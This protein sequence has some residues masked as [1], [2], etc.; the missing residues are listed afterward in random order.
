MGEPYL[1]LLP[2]IDAWVRLYVLISVK[3]LN[4]RME[5]VIIL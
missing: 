4:T 5:N 3:L 1:V 2:I